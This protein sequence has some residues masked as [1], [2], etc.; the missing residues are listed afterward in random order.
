MSTTELSLCNQAEIVEKALIGGDLSKLSAGE[1]T[2]YYLRVCESL[3]LNPMTQP[4]QFIILNGKLT[5][6]A[7]KD[8]TEQLRKA[9]RVSLSIIDRQRLEDVYIVT[10]KAYL[11][12][13]R[14]DESTGVV[15]IGSLK[16]DSLANALMKAETKAK[17]RVT[18]SICGLGMLDESETETI[19]NAQRVDFD[20]N[21]GEVYSPSQPAPAQQQTRPQPP[22]APQQTQQTQAA[23]QSSDQLL[24][25]QQVKYVHILG[26]KKFGKQGEEQFRIFMADVIG[27]RCSTKLMTKREASDVIEQLQVLP[28]YV[29][30]ADPAQQT[31]FEDPKPAEPEQPAPV[32][33]PAAAAEPIAPPGHPDYDPFTDPV[34]NSGQPDPGE[35]CD[36][37]RTEIV[38]TTW[39]GK[40]MNALE[41]VKLSID[42]S[43]KKLCPHCLSAYLTA[44]RKEE[45]AAK[46]KTKAA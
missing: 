7:K 8:C 9:Q 2:N 26:S 41:I 39:G 6:Y 31:M 33:Q 13:G 14:T 30:P 28:D 24:T 16:G 11:P 27:R 35:Y 44:K 29:E 17:R 43:G 21:T 46:T 12:D 40:Q 1:R 23:S 15:S 10:A 19:P 22:Q 32:E 38:G 5:L 3:G 37:C 36:E 18:L 42:Q 34:I 4:F 45:K 20:V 25:E